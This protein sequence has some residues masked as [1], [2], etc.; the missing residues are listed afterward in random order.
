MQAPVASQ[1]AVGEVGTDRPDRRAKAR[2]QTVAGGDIGAQTGVP[3]VARVDEPGDAPVVAEP[4]RVFDAADE[5]APSADHG[6]GLLDADALESI[7]AHRLV[8]A[9]A[10]QE[11]AGNPFARLRAHGARLAA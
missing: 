6:A 1:R 10:E 3:G 7:A 5:Q 9:G 11:G 4:V 8:A 2:A